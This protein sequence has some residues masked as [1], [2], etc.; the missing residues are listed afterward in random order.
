MAH[1]QIEFL[2][3]TVFKLVQSNLSSPSND[4]AQ[5]DDLQVVGEEVGKEKRMI[6]VKYMVRVRLEGERNFVLVYIFFRAHLHVRQRD[7]QLTL[8]WIH[9]LPLGEI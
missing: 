9:I 7:G 5:V 1:L 8:C 3:A 2:S 6:D 4:S